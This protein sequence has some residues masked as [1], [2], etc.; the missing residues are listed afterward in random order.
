[1]RK[2]KPLPVAEDV[3]IPC[4]RKLLVRVIGMKADHRANQLTITL[5][6]MNPENEGQTRAVNVPLPIRPSSRAGRFFA[7]CGIHV[8]DGAEITEDAVVGRFVYVQFERLPVAEMGLWA[9]FEPVKQEQSH[10]QSAE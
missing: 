3:E 2:R 8:G 1:M 6:H 4:G 7:A 9:T 10:G 5:E